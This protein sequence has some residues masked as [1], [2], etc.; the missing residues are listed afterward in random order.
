MNC[1]H[2]CKL[3]NNRERMIK[4]AQDMSVKYSEPYVVHALKPNVYDF[5]TKKYAID[6]KLSWVYETE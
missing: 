2:G 4:V 6:N 1:I 5:V 3:A